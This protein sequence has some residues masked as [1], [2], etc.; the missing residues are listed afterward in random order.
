MTALPEGLHEH[1]ILHSGSDDVCAF[2]MPGP[3]GLYCAVRLIAHQVA[4]VRDATDSSMRPSNTK[5]EG[6]ALS[7]LCPKNAQILRQRTYR[8]KNL[9]AET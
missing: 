7:H 9:R 4:A 5:T 8:W 2:R 3:P 1:A 6:E